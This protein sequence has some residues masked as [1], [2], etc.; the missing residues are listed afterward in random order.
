MHP[1]LVAQFL[2]RPSNWRPI[3]GVQGN[4][5]EFTWEEAAAALAGVD[6]LRAGAFLLRFGRVDHASDCL[7]AYLL[8]AATEAARCFGNRVTGAALVRRLIAEELMPHAAR[9]G[10]ERA[11]ALRMTYA[12]YRRYA[13]RPFARVSQALDF[14]VDDAWRTVRERLENRP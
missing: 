12:T 5:P 13:A 10:K 2:D 9:T 3:T 7:K 1:A 8:E 6:D 4:R 14:L 11:I